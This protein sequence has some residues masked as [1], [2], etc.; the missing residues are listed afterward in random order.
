MSKELQ[1]GR[2]FQ[3]VPQNVSEA[4]E[5]AKMIAGSDLAPRDYKD[6]PGNVLIAIQMGAEVG[7]APMQAVQNIAVING[8]P[9]VWGDALLAIV[10]VHPDY[11][12]IK[13]EQTETEATCIIKR[14][15]HDP[16]TV[17]F[18]LKD[19]VAAGLDKK[20]GTWQNYRRRMLQM[21]ARGWALRDRFADAT[22]GLIIIEEAA[23]MEPEQIEI[24]VADGGKKGQSQVKAL[25]AKLTP[26]LPPEPPQEE[27]APNHIGEAAE[28]P[29]R[30]DEPPK[31]ASGS[32]G[33]SIFDKVVEFFN[34]EQTVAHDFIADTI[35]PKEIKSTA[36]LTK[37][38]IKKI[39]DAMAEMTAAVE[40][41]NS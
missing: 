1:V 5:L 6:K 24:Q 26:E 15:N 27:K 28:M 32:I 3:I 29:P 35:K 36:E 33:K 34:G 17:V 19:A 8:R 39:Q 12:W 38:D 25:K 37:A 10:Q 31:K 11:E 9:S 23:D 20:P 14:R 21:R 4:M 2:P 18:G 7:L 40:N 16:H 30:D 41:S 13:E 22:K